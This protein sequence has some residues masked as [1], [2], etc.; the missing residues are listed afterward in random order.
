MNIRC[1]Q[2]QFA[3]ALYQENRIGEP[4]LQGTH[5][6]CGTIRRA[7]VDHQHMKV[8]LQAVNGLQDWFQC[9]PFV[10]GWY[11]YKFLHKQLVKGWFPFK[12]FST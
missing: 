10:I 9:F 12:T 5:H 3:A 2:T 8:L 7:I 6:I 4:R 11:Y 1:A